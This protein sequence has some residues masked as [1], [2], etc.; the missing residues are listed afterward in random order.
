MARLQGSRRTR[1]T[2]VVCGIALAATLGLMLL[3]PA[4]G[5]TYDEPARQHHGERVLAF[6]RG[7]LTYADFAPDGSGRH[8]YGALFDT[9][10]AWLHSRLGGD[11]WQERHRLGAAF[12]GL[13]L[14]ATGLLAA[15]L[16]G[17]A[18]GVLAIVF[19]ALSP[20]FV[21]HAAN[22]PKDIPFAVLCAV[23]LLAYSLVRRDPP[24]VSW[25]RAAIVGLAL[26][27]PLNVRPGG[28]LYLAYFGGLLAAM[29][30]RSRTWSSRQLVSIAARMIV[31]AA[32]T[33]AAGTIF[34]PWAQQNPLAR[35]FAAIFQ[36]SHFR[37]DGDVLFAGE[38]VKATALPWT[39]APVWIAITT[40][41]V[42][43]CG[44]LFAAV[45]TAFGAR[46]ERSWRAGLWTVG[47]APVVL[48][49]ARHSTLYDGWR[50]LLFVYPPLVVLAAV[51][52]RS[53]I[54]G[55]RRYRFLSAFAIAALVAGCL[56]PTIFMVRNH[57][58]EI[59]YFNALVG[60]PHGAF[61][62]YEL[63]YWGNSLLQAADW[64][65][66]VAACAG[67]PVVVSGWPYQIVTED[68]SRFPSVHSAQPEQEAHHLELRLLRDTRAGLRKT[69]A[70]PDILHVVRTDDG[71][72]LAVVLQGPRFNEIEDPLFAH[73][74]EPRRAGDEHLCGA[75]RDE[76]QRG[77]SRYRTDTRS[78]A[79]GRRKTS[80]IA[81][82]GS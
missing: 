58:N 12:A 11:L 73:G 39:Y 66:G 80:A 28:L 59:V 36:V 51:G 53:A 69:M 77:V 14:L 2:L 24:F 10:A 72:P 27:L 76:L 16:A 71:A 6:L 67:R 74:G 42:V 21:G 13:G 70:R 48:A 49:I 30:I 55:A 5:V 47:L 32:V 7:R 25:G 52:W 9:S 40:P 65:A 45:A 44:L 20:R 26:A 63:D 57:P 54:L 60:G 78:A 38:Q 82:A 4:Y 34:W 19:L 3:A 68:A 46:N 61:K 79:A 31:V 75:I 41:P 37:W 23:C 18:T 50:H 33:L 8:L 81:P 56:Q 62:H 1:G 43:L 35:P 15:R 22:N 29:T 64:T 17:A